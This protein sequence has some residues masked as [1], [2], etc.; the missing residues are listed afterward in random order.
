MR[1]I[2]G[3]LKGRR[4]RPPRW[5]GLRPTSDRLRE[6]LFNVLGERVVAAGV[7]DACAGT[8]ALGF[9]ALSR[10]ARAAAFVEQDRR[11][12]DLI[13]E[14]AAR[15]GVAE[16]CRIVRG[17][18]PQVVDDGRLADTY[19]VILLDP[20]YD[21]PEIGA[22]L[23]AVGRA[24]GRR[25]SPGAGARAPG[26]PAAGGRSGVGPRDRLRRQRARL[27]HAAAGRQSGLTGE[28]AGCR[29]IILRV[30]PCTPGRS[31]R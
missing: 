4:L 18:L 12:A 6:T 1:I 29:V 14:H 23:S 27:L 28:S 5:A 15:F 30:W 25:G 16:R 7:L 21:N 19:D 20:P 11:A 31:T 17:P 24:A 13:A 10:G 2:A 3:S 22:I 9:E 26:G 8:G